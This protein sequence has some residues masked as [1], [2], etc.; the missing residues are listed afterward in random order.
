MFTAFSRW[1]QRFVGMQH[2]VAISV[3]PGF[4]VLLTIHSVQLSQLTSGG[5]DAM[6]MWMGRAHSSPNLQTKMQQSRRTP[7]HVPLAHREAIGHSSEV[8]HPSNIRQ[9]PLKQME[10]FVV[11]LLVHH[12]QIYRAL[13][14]N[15][16]KREHC[17]RGSAPTPSAFLSMPLTEKKADGFMQLEGSVVR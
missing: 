17:Q 8:C 15:S 10:I 6:Q 1:Y 7:L 5:L 3:T 13:R 14:R 11:S 4:L 9:R 12:R 2:I 16:C